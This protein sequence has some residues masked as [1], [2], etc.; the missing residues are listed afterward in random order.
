[1][2]NKATDETTSLVMA[3]P[4]SLVLT[5]VLEESKHVLRVLLESVIAD[6]FRDRRAAIATGIGCYDAVA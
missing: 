5:Q 4:Y 1:M 3:Y 6:S 2:G